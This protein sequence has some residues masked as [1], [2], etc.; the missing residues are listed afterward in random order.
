[1]PSSRRVRVLEAA[2]DFVEL[3]ESKKKWKEILTAV[4]FQVINKGNEC[5]CC[6]LFLKCRFL[7]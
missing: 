4:M 3:A 5:D 1:L 7:S 6:L 2:K